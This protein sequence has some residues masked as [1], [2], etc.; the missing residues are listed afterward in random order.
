MAI[1]KD[2]RLAWHERVLYPCVRVRTAKAGGSGTVIYSEPDPKNPEEYL[3][4]VLTNWHV[5]EGA[6]EIKDEWD[7]LLKRQ[8]KRDFTAEVTVET[9]TYHKLSRVVSANAHAAEIVAYDRGHDLAVLRIL[10]P[11]QYRY[12]ATLLPETYVD[13]LA[14]GMPVY[15]VGCSLLHDP[16]PT[17]GILTSL[18]EII[19]NK[20]Y[21]MVSA[22]GIFGNSGG[23]TYVQLNEAEPE[24][25]LSGVVSRLQAIQLG[26]GVDLVTWMIFTAHPVRIYQFFREQELHF[27]YDKSDNY[28]EAL[29]RREQKR[30][31]ERYRMLHEGS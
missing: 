6:I 23:A 5:V 25:Y 2:L 16:L 14:L 31:Q 21:M 8:V 22:P 9:F 29:K 28:Y 12:P 20:Q 15:N 24:W 11:A 3:T 1:P 27:L 13:Q 10:S 30:E 17:E 7:S 26:F 19:E 4:F 18:R